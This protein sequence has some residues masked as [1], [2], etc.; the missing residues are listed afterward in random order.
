MLSFHSVQWL[1]VSP[2]LMLLTHSFRAPNKNQH[3]WAFKGSSIIMLHCCSR[4][5]HDLECV[6]QLGPAK[7]IDQWP[8]VA[9]LTPCGVL[10]LSRW[11]SW[12]SKPLCSSS[13]YRHLGMLWLLQATRSCMFVLQELI[14]PYQVKFLLVQSVKH[15][16]KFLAS[17]TLQQH[18]AINIGYHSCSLFHNTLTAWDVALCNRITCRFP[19]TIWQ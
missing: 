10:R 16:I 17:A 19:V 7:R 6:F 11:L 2:S 9:R 8:D 5:T 15:V 3:T 12:C 13:S 14:L 4:Q 18:G 1:W